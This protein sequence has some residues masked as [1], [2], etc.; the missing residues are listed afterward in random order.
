MTPRSFVSPIGLVAG[1]GSFPSEFVR[2]AKERGLEVVVVAHQGESDPTLDSIAPGTLWIKVGQLGK[3]ISHL[4]AKRVSQVA[5]AGG[6][7]R[8]RLFQNVW[9]D[10]RGAA[11]IARLGSVKDDIVLRG[12]AAELEREGMEVFSATELLDKSTPAAGCFG[13]RALSRV[14]AAEAVLGWEAAEAIGRLDIG[15]TVVVTKGVISAVEAVEGTDAAI[16]R[17]GQL[18]GG[19]SVVV[20]LPKPQQDLR[21]DLPAVGPKTI[22]MLVKVEATALVLK[23]SGAVILQPL[24]VQSLA[25]ANQI[26]IEVFDS[27]D[28]LKRR[29]H[30]VNV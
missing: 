25:N 15:Q 3:M 1:G 12:V 29:A 21:L 6:I 17:A 13:R 19:G 8:I 20:K 30:A 10:F 9:L 16:I 26:A 23:S 2:R 24:E 28:D 14:E 11:L 5:F 18:A 27:I 22:E 7:S 4:K